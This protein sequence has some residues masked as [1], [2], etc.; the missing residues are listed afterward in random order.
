MGCSPY[1]LIVAHLVRFV[2][3]FFYFFL[4]FFVVGEVG[5]DPTTLE[6]NGF[7]DRRVCRFSVLSLVCICIIAQI[8]KFVKGFFKIFLKKLA[9]DLLGFYTVPLFQQ[10]ATPLSC[11][12]LGSVPSP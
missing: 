12:T 1:I 8:E 5:A 6:R 7:T 3:N 2:K 10:F 9:T 4:I 11:P